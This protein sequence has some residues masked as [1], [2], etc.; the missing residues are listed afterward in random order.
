MTIVAK[1]CAILNVSVIAEIAEIK[2]M[3]EHRRSLFN[4]HNVNVGI[5]W[6]NEPFCAKRPVEH[7]ILGGKTHPYITMRLIG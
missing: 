5:E 3:G 4:W 1:H 7:K 6:G 2:E